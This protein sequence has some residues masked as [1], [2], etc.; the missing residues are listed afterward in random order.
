MVVFV[1]LI[2]DIKKREGGGKISSLP[3]QFYYF[4][5]QAISKS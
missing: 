5:I 3:Q 1:F 2:Y 4:L